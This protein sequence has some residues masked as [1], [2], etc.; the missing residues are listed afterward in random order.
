MEAG[1]AAGEGQEGRAGATHADAEKVGMLQRE[2]FRQAGHKVGER[3]DWCQRSSKK[4]RCSSPLPENI[5]AV[6]TAARWRLWT[7]SARE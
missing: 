6:S 2:H 5:W 4:Q 3:Y 7:A 1:L